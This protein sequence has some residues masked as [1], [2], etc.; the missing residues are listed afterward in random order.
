MHCFREN[1]SKG[2]MVHTAALGT[3]AGATDWVTCW[4]PTWH[5]WLTELPLAGAGTGAMGAEIP[6]LSR[7][8]P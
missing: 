1:V 4:A 5:R 6:K 8:I 7:N 3:G 2:H